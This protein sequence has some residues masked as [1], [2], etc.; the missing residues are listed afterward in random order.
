MAFEL[1]E[2]QKTIIV[3]RR[4]W[5]VIFSKILS[6]SITIIVLIGLLIFLIKY[7]NY[8]DVIL[9]IVSFLM[10]GLII[11]FH[12]LTDYYLDIWVVTNRRSI[13]IELKGFFSRTIKSIHHKRVQEIKVNVKGLL[14]TILNYGDI[15]IQTA[16]SQ[17]EF[18]FKEIPN[19]HNVKKV[20]YA[21]AEKY[22]KEQ[23]DYLRK[24]N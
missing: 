15:R 21:A 12:F 17:T 7:L 1:K 23:Q 10:L 2:G 16:G 13:R 3:E 18:I 14:P 24:S 20:I 19:P 11:V 6:F 9:G 5:F 4:H 22:Q 8:P